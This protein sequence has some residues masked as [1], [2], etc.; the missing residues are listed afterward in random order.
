MVFLIVMGGN[1]RLRPLPII[2]K[3]YSIDPKS[4]HRFLGKLMGNKKNYTHNIERFGVMGIYEVRLCK[5]TLPA[6]TSLN[7]LSIK[8]RH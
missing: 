3:I 8:K 2:F 4:G 6:Q 1:G 7:D 5:K